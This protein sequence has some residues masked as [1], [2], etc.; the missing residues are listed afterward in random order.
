M[1]PAGYINPTA[2]PPQILTSCMTSQHS[3]VIMTFL[4]SLMTFKAYFF[5]W[6]VNSV[7]LG[8]D[9]RPLFHRIYKILEL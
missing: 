2:E 5:H 9:Q 7:L 3:V 4:F 6:T 1:V 8:G